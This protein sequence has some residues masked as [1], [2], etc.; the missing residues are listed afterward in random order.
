MLWIP[1]RVKVGESF[2]GIELG[3]VMIPALT[4][5]A[6]RHADDQVRLGWMNDWEE[7]EGGAPVPMGQKMLLVDGEEFPLLE[8][9]ELRI[10][11]ASAPE[12]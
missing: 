12:G 5:G 3:E 7:T 2:T 6:F 8:L 11:A 10:E 1:A 9:R 4:P